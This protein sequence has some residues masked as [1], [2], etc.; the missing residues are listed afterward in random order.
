[1]RGMNRSFHGMWRCSST[2]VLTLAWAAALGLSTAAANAQVTTDMLIGAQELPDQWLHYNRNYAGWRYMP[3]DQIN[4]ETVSRLEPIW[5]IPVNAGRGQFEVSAVVSDGRMYISTQNNHLIVVDPTNGEILWRYDYELPPRLNVCCGPV[6]RGVVVYGDRVYWG[7][8]DAHLL[9]FDAASGEVLWNTVVAPAAEGYSVTG[10]PLFVRGNVLVGVGGGEF[11]IRGFIAAY[12]AQTGEQAWR[13]HT[14]PGPGE[15]GNET[16][17]GD[18]WKHGGAATWVTGTYDPDLNLVYWGT[19]NPGPD[20]NRDL[21]EGINLYSNSVVALNGD[22]GELVWY[23]QASP[24]DEFDW[25]GVGEPVLVD[26]IILGEPVKAVV[27]A[28][29]N[30]FL[31]ALDRTDG[32]FLYAKP[33]SKANWYVYDDQGIP[34]LKEELLGDDPHSVIPGLFGGKNWPPS[35]YS[36]KTHYLYIP[37]IEQGSTFESREEEFRPGRYFMAGSNKFDAEKK[38]FVRAV[39]LRNGEVQWEFETPGGPNWAGL[40]ATGGGLVFGGAPDGML[41]AFN[42]QTGEV[43]W[44]FKTFG[45]DQTAGVDI[46]APP[47]SF[48]LDGKQVIGLAVG[49]R[50]QRDGGRYVLFGLRDG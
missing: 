16:W 9:C 22:T 28:N 6:N 7:T 39:D 44:E 42:D 50:R 31:Y 24:R 27:Q 10:A 38:G 36:P 45:A 1:M 43:L 2:S 26:E 32:R 40:L 48:T 34:V 4:R 19:G 17:A 12:D 8:L 13:F 49:G 29:R 41:R 35:S 11:G 21:R 5:S 37:D 14:I 46:M 3:V 20:L 25:D 18:S 33:Y 23:F 15:P 47:T 30:G